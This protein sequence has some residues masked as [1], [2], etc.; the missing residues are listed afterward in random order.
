[1]RKL[2]CILSFLALAAMIGLDGCQTPTR[3]YGQ[4]SPLFLPGRKR[5]VWAVAPVIN[6]SGQKQVDPI[7]QAD[8]VYQ[9]L[10][11][12]QGLTVIPVDRVVE[13]YIALRIDQVQ[14][15][16][17]ASAVC[18]LL[19]CDALVVTTITQ[20]DPYEPPK[21]GGSLQLLLKDE[22]PRPTNADWR[23]MARVA[24][25]S[26]TR[27]AVTSDNVVQVVGMY[28]AA[29]GSVRAALFRYADGRSDPAGPLGAMIYLKDADRYC[30]FVYHA[31]IAELLNKPRL[32]RGS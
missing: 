9:Q 7:L 22:T 21:L 30:G 6:L 23:E 1:M 13:L 24:A 29:N 2:R 15:P 16:Q 18:E 17:Q 3:D 5:Q 4:E 26:P 25:T 14:T 12:V 28:D 10:Q 8:L 27:S 19:G 31:L 32:K 11:Q 20:Y